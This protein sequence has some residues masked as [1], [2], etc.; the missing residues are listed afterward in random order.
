MMAGVTCFA[1]ADGI[2]ACLQA[3]GDGRGPGQWAEQRR[4]LDSEH[5][6]WMGDLNYRLS[7]ADDKVYSC[8]TSN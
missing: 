8:L 3:S 5:T 6:I 2:C 4:L 1:K 7:I